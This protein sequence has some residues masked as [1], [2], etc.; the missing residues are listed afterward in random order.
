M[1]L[2]ETLLVDELFFPRTSDIHAEK[3][4][5]SKCDY[6]IFDLNLRVQIAGS[7][8]FHAMS[9]KLAQRN[10]VSFLAKRDRFASVPDQLGVSAKACLLFV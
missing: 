8:L 3:H 5:E 7:S 2:S 4:P 9:K 10:C 6:T 1:V